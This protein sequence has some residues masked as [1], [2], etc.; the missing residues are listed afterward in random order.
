MNAHLQELVDYIQSLPMDV[1]LDIRNLFQ[2]D[3]AECEQLRVAQQRAPSANE[4][5]NH[6]KWK[7]QQHS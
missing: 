6:G 4:K 1:P 5:K 7:A 3:A 2:P